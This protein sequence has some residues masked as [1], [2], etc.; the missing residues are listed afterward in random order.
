MGKRAQIKKI[1]KQQENSSRKRPLFDLRIFLHPQF[2]I[3]IAAF[4]LVLGYP[5]LINTSWYKNHL[6]KPSAE[7]LAVKNDTIA[8]I[9]TAK[10]DIVFQLYRKDA[11]LTT[12]NFIRLAVRGYYNGLTFHR[13]V[14]G[15]V[16]QGGDP[17]GTGS[18]GESA[19]GGTF[20]D[21]INLNSPLY[22]VGYIEGTVAMAN[23]GPNTNG[24]QF[25]ITL[26]D[27]P[28]LPKDYTIFG[29]VTEGMNVALQIKKGD[30]MLKVEVN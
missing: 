7:D 29:H 16:I 2:W 26:A 1:K 23:S 22:K 12:E 9:V 10:G 4:I 13:V 5:I 19:W 30:K 28:N 14:P 18:G 25:F 15:F 27:Q 11:P 8:T 24:S 17:T 20:K 6:E 3:A 21:E